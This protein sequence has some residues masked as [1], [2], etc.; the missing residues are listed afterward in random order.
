MKRFLKFILPYGLVELRR[1]RRKLRDIGTRLSP[2]DWFRTDALVRK[3]E[4]TGLSLFPPGHVQNLKCIVDV[5]ANTGQW[6]RTLLD[7]ATP[8]RLIVI[9]P[10]PAAYRELQRKFEADQRVQLHHTAIGDREGTAQLKIT[11]DTTGASLLAPREEMRAVIGSNWTVVSEVEVPITTLDRLLANL[12]EVSLLKID[13]QGFEQPVLSGATK[14]LAKT[15]FL[16][17]ELNY[18]PQYEGGSWL[19]DVHDVL[20]REHGF[21]L[22]NSSM[23]LVLNGRASMCDGLYVNPRLVP[24]FVQPDFF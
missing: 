22:A 9:E 21:F 18:M 14:T 15:K 7:I 19:G 17:I 4:W 5:G 23:P 8:E 20:T 1:N 12:P 3:A 24:D 10:E 16:L 11:R 13:V 6:S 2:A